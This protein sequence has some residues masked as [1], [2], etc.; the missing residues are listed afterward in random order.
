MT[1]GDHSKVGITVNEGARDRGL[2]R[3][4]HD[5]IGRCPAIRLTS[6]QLRHACVWTRGMP[7]A[8]ID[9]VFEVTGW[10]LCI[11]GAMTRAEEAQA[12]VQLAE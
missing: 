8:S 7:L 9:P 11:V 12:A 6:R 2:I 3:A 1:L 4:P 5:G 10:C